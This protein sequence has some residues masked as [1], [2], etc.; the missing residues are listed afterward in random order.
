MLLCRLGCN[1][2]QKHSLSDSGLEEL[3]LGEEFD[4]MV[5]RVG[6]PVKGRP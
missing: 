6:L 5:L 4:V 2:L 1:V 3:R